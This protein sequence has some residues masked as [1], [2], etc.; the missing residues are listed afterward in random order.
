MDPSASETVPTTTATTDPV[1]SS[2]DGDRLRHII[3]VRCF[4]AFDGAREAPQDAVCI[5]G[6]PVRAGDRRPPGGAMEC[7]LCNELR[8]H[9]NRE[10]HSTN[11]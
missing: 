3:C 10:R 7:I 4:P 2:G 5:C 11:Q 6:K 9:H 8:G 1:P